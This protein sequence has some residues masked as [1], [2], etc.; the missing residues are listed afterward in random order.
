MLLQ[1]IL[2]SAAKE[3]NNEQLKVFS[4][5]LSVY[6]PGKWLHIPQKEIASELGTQFTCISRAMKGLS[7]KGYIEII[8]KGGLN[9][10]KIKPEIDWVKS[11]DDWKIPSS[12]RITGV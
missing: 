5:L 1:D 2:I 9:F 6:I 4:Y 8:K 11:I 12:S 7:Q 10:Y 3:L